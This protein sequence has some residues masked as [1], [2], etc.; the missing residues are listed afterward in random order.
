MEG[1]IAVV[2]LAA[3]CGLPLLIALLFKRR[4]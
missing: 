2:L 4:E 1:L 3:C